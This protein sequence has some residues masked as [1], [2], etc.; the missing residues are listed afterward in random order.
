MLNRSILEHEEDPNDLEELENLSRK[1]I[2][3]IKVPSVPEIEEEKCGVS[4]R[5]SLINNWCKR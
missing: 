5:D 2:A 1:N 4:K 3:E